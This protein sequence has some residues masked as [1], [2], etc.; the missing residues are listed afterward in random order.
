MNTSYQD[1]NKTLYDYIVIHNKNMGN[2][3]ALE[4]FGRKYTFNEILEN[5]NKV[6]K[7]LNELGLQKGDRISIL[8]LATPEYVFMLYAA[9][10]MGIVLNMLN[11]L[12]SGSYD[13]II[14]R[15]NPKLVLCYEKFF[16]LIEDK[17][18][19]E[20]I[21]IT[22]PTDS[23][24]KVIQ[25]A[26][27]L[28]SFLKQEKVKIP[29]DCPRWQE[30]INKGKESNKKLQINDEYISDSPALELGTGGTTG[31]PK[32]VAITNEILNNIVYQHHLMN[33]S[34]MFDVTFNDNDVFL[35]IIP[36]HLAYGVCDV[37][38][39]MALRLELHLEPDPNPKK[40]IEQLK[41]HNPHH[42]LAAPVHWK[43]LIAY[44]KKINLS[45][46]KNAV[47]GGEHLETDDE[48]KT[49]KKLK[50]YNAPSNVREGVG[51][52]EICGVG[53]YNSNGDL[54]TVGRPLPD[55]QV[56]IFKIGED[57]NP[58]TEEIAKICYTKN[59]DGEYEIV[60]FGELG[61]NNFGEVC[62]Q[63]PVKVLGYVGSE[64]KKENE[65]L[66]RKHD[67]GLIWIH[68]GDIGHIREDINLIITDRLKRMFNR[69]SFKIYPTHLSDI[70]STSGLVKENV[71]VKR[72]SLDSGENYAPVLYASLKENST[73][74]ELEEWCIQNLIGN[75]SLCDII[76][77]DELPKTS[78]GK[79]DFKVVE[80]Y[81]E[82]VYPAV[83]TGLSFESRKPKTLKLQSFYKK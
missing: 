69:Y 37:H 65:T 61:E 72:K 76:I 6:M 21:I 51:L 74:Q 38:L 49:N 64:Y 60:A 77:V 83:D 58:T 28:K 31:I 13:K 59:K 68:S 15:L 63:L 79:I 70:V 73:Y 46:L 11:P 23:L 41:K 40:F 26:D 80:A 30:F 22:S 44:E 8:G 29:S 78:A 25:I 45:R 66:I 57:G 32:Q 14:N 53:T 19:P 82:M 17:I 56:G 4:Y 75:N 10:K 48:I 52:T 81:D 18:E 50:Q 5:I 1:I 36:P 54:F 33:S 24:P 67:D 3:Y 12:D 43:E 62:Y 2:R 35:D 34:N 42:V 7:S 27:N 71:I 20:R 9:N 47:A 16:P 39:A 55:Y